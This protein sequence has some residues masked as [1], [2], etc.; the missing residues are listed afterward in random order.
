MARRSRT[1]FVRPPERTK[2]WIGS[3]IGTTTL[4]ASQ[5]VLLSTLSAGAK[6][7]RPFTILRTRMILSFATDQTGA[8]ELPQGEYGKIVVTDTAASVGVTA[9]PNPSSTNGDSEADWFVYQSV[10][11]QILFGSN[12]GL[13]LADHQYIIDSKAMRKVGPDD[14]ICGVFTETAGYGA[15]LVT[16]GRMLIQLH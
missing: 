2:M 8:I 11:A 3:G 13:T 16:R 1:R 12:V 10:A 15:R 4:A 9:V 7:L 14:D 5:K 6:L